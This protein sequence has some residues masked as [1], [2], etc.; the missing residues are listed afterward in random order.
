MVDNILTEYDNLTTTQINNNDG[1]Y[2]F[3]I[4]MPIRSMTTEKV[5]ELLKEREKLTRELDI[6]TI[7]TSK[8]L[9]LEDLNI[10]ETDYKKHMNDFYEYT[11][12]T[13][14]NEYKSNHIKKIN[15]TITKKIKTK[16]I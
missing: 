12:I 3:L 10:F 7:K 13:P 15:N 4:T 11:K 5:D 8:D 14:N 16:Q 1:S 6:L 2:D 9:W